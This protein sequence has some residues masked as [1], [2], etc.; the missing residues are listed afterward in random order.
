M[1]KDMVHN[2]YRIL[3]L[4]SFILF[5]TLTVSFSGCG[6][7]GDSRAED[8]LDGIKSGEEGRASF[9]SQYSP[10]VFLKTWFPN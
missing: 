1:G 9:A 6:E 3:K 5:V 2:N 7:N 8:A 4:S 10:T